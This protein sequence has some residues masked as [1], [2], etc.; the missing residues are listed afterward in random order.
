M[1]I[2]KVCCWSEVFEAARKAL[3]ESRS[4]YPVYLSPG[5]YEL[6]LE[7]GLIDPNPPNDYLLSEKLLLN[8]IYGSNDH[9]NVYVIVG[10]GA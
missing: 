5:Q 1:T 9:G 2:P 6:A 4:A 10:R 8:S 7:L 3:A